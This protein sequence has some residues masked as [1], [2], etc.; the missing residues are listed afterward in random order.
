M[1]CGCQKKKDLFRV[2]TRGGAGRA[3]FSNSSKETTI[4]I[5]KKYEG[6]VVMDKDDK[7]VH[8]NVAPVST[9]VPSSGQPSEVAE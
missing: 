7:I 3:V 5:S 8:T 4:A 1:A 6:S 2:V 9:S